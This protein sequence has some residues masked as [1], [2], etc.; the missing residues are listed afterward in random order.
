MGSGPATGGGKP[1]KSVD[2]GAQ[3][4]AAIVVVV[5]LAGALWVLG[6]GR[7]AAGDTKP[8]VCD[9][10]HDAKSTTHVVAAGLC[11]ALNRSD[12]PTLLGTPDEQAISA[13]G[14]VSTFTSADGTKTDSPE[15]DV[16]LK[17]YSLELSASDDD[18]PVSELAAFLGGTVQRRSFLGHPA[19]LYSDHTTALRFNLGGG[20]VHTGPGGVARTLIV[21]KDAKDG[22]GSFEV[23]IWRQDFATPDDA[24][25]FRVA[26]KVLPTVPGWTAG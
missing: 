7:D 1:E 22:G 11:T 14:N 5:G 19:V 21:A 20:K 13:S 25:L 3:V 10:T 4:I 24:A 23:S 12:L 15:A 16:D 26:E 17:T 8:A 2:T 6:G 18:F 9:T